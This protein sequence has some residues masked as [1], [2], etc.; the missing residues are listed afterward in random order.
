MINVWHAFVESMELGLP[1]WHSGT[2]AQLH[3]SSCIYYGT[4]S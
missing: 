2:V 3:R 1:L 4:I